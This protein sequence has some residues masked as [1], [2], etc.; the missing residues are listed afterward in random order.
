MSK[1]DRARAWA[2]RVGAVARRATTRLRNMLPHER[3]ALYSLPLFVVWVFAIT[4]ERA[5]TAL[6]AAGRN[7]VLSLCFLLAVG[8]IF[9]FES[10]VTSL[11]PESGYSVGWVALITHGLVALAYVVCSAV[12]SFREYGLRP[13]D[14]GQLDRLA[15]RLEAWASR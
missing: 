15:G 3:A 1:V 8:A 4:W 12:L 7:Q 14:V 9:L 13:L 5:P 11:F 2:K 6:R 10:V